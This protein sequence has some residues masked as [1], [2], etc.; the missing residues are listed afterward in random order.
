M[1]IYESGELSWMAGVVLV[2][3]IYA[4]FMFAWSRKKK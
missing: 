1:L 3:I 2:G 4:L